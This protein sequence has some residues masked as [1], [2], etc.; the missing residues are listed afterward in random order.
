MNERIVK[1]KLP[2]WSETNSSWYLLTKISPNGKGWS[3]GSWFPKKKCTLKESRHEKEVGIL[4]LPE[5]LFNLKSDEGVDF[6]NLQ[7]E[8]V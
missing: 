3:C 4:T 1:V 7:N 2:V 6:T 5:W 8:I